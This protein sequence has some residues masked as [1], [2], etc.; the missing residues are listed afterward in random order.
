MDDTN[1]LPHVIVTGNPFDG[2]T[3]IGPFDNHEAALT[4]ADTHT[5]EWDWWVVPV[6]PKE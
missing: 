1:Q 5:F 3:L 4:Y 2:L 6:H